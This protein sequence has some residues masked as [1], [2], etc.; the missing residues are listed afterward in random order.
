M[1]RREITLL[2]GPTVKA[3]VTKQGL[4]AIHKATHKGYVITHLPT[5]RVVLWT[6][7]QTD[8][9]MVRKELELMD[10]SDLEAIRAR[11]IQL[12]KEYC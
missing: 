7:R 2:N 5:G 8:A 6:P 11:V 10:W 1:A 12:R 3:E 9:K 4:L